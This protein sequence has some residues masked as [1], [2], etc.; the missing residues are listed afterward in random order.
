MGES[1]PV[2]PAGP[3]TQAPMKPEST[4]ARLGAVAAATVV[5]ISSA[6]AADYTWQLA[7][8][9]NNWSTAGGDTNWFVGGVGPL[10]AWA[11]GNAAILDDASG[12]TITLIGTVAPTSTTVN[13]NG[14]WALSG[15]GILGGSGTLVKNGTGTLTLSNTTANTYS[16]GTTVNGGILSLGTGGTGA[17]TSTVSALGS[18][19]ATLNTGSTLRLWIRNNAA[20]TIANNLSIAG[21]TILNED[22]NHTLAGNVT[23]GSGGATLRSKWN[24]KNLTL[25]GVMSGTGAVT[26][27]RSETSGESSSK[28]ILTNSNSHSGGTTVSSAVLDL[29]NNNA[30]DKG[31]TGVVRGTL[32]VNSPG[33][34]NLSFSNALGYSGGEKVDTLNINGATVSHTANEDQGWGIT[35]NMTGGTL[36]STG[37]GR[38]TFGDNSSLNTLAS[39]TSATVAG[40]LRI[41]EGNTGNNINF[42][43]ADGTT[44]VDLAMNAVIEQG[45]AGYGITKLG[46]GLMQLNAAN[47]YSGATNVNAGTLSLGP[48]GTLASSPVTVNSGGTFRSEVTGKTLPAMTANNGSTLAMVAAP[49]ATTNVTGALTLTNGATINVAPILGGA[50]VPGTYDLITAGSIT[51]TGSLALT[52]GGTYGPSRASGTVSINGNKIQLVI[53]GTGASLIWNNASASGVATGTW[54]TNTTA[55]FNNGGGNDVFKAFDSVTFNDTVAAGQAKTINVAGTVAPALITANN[56]TGNNY[57]L[58][59]LTAGAGTI[60]G[61]PS[62]NKIGTGTLTLGGN[63]NYLGVNGDFTAGGGTLD[64]G[65]KTLPTQ[66]KLTVSGGGTLSNGTLPVSGTFD[67][68]QG[69]VSAVLTGGGTFTKTTANTVILSGNNAISGAG[70]VSAGTLQIGSAGTTGALGS[71]AVT[72]SSGATLALNRSDSGLTFAN[73]LSGSGALALNGTNNGVSN[74]QSSYVIDGINSGFSGT[75]TATNGRARINNTTDTGTATLITGTNGGFLIEAGTF[76]N[77]FTLSGNGWGEAAGLLGALR[78]QGGTITGPIT[79]AGNARI[80]TQGGSGTISGNIGESGGAR[81]LEFGTTGATTLLTLSGASNYTGTTTLTAANLTLSGSLGNTAVSVANTSTLGGK[82]SIGGSL[83]FSGAATNLG[84]N[85]GLP[86]T[87]TV[88]GNTTFGGVTTVALTPAPGLTPGGIITLINYGSATGTTANL[89]L[90]NAAQYRQ[91]L[92]TVGAT[93]L[94]LNVGTKALTWTGTGGLTWDIATTTNWTDTVPA[95]SAYFQGDTVTFSDTAGAGNASVTVAAAL[96][97]A[98]VTVNNTGAVPYTFGGAG[99]VGGA[100][101]LVKTGNGSATLLMNMPYTGGTTVNGGSLIVDGNQEGNRQANGG[102]VTVNSGGTFEIR[103]VNA[104]PSAGNSINVT[105]NSGTLRVVTGTSAAFPAATQSHAHLGNLTLNAGT[106]DFTY[107][108]TGSAYNNESFQFNGTLTVGGSAASTIQSAESTANQGIALSGNRTFAVAD[109]TGNASPDLIITAEVENSDSNNGALT[110]TGT[111]TLSLTSANSYSAGTTIS[112]GTLLAD[113]GFSGSATGTGAVSV[114]VGATLGGDGGATGAITAAGTLAPGN[115]TTPL[116][117][118]RLGA[119]TLTGSYACQING[120]LFDELDI[121]GNLVLTG[122][123]LALSPTGAGATEASY[124]LASWTG[125]RTGTFTTVTGLPGGYFLIYDDVLKELRID[126]TPGDSYGAWEAANGIS[127]SGPDADPD[128]DGIKNGIEFVIGGDPSGPGSVSAALLPT[129]ALDGTYLNVVYRRTDDSAAFDPFVEYGS[130]LTGWT[131]AQA[132]VNGVLVSEDN[133]FYGAGIDRVTVRIPRALA[134]GSRLFA[135]LHV[136]IP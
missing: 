124:V 39:T 60:A 101:S 77:A 57:T 56:S 2:E 9:T 47:T 107:A 105:L 58:T 85:L 11:D 49:S 89:A 44:E 41:R 33:A 28:V 78:L 131:E 18:G 102:Q 14:T 3:E 34:L 108:T 115:L 16:A 68:Q 4:R 99:S 114:A 121:T 66:A 132:G 19:T 90:A 69:T 35:V 119:T 36:Q 76:A 100:A 116:G 30:T 82:G 40:F 103:G 12:E 70:T 118:L 91:A 37:T 38:F 5:A 62:I 93:S 109:A 110:K 135:R 96:T 1:G 73:A 83:N 31:G 67:F 72:I 79:L 134:V 20:F 63:L 48:N 112:A 128:S 46:T 130:A 65:A 81:N 7:G 126:T 8:T 94:T 17:D 74:G 22:G 24:G 80:T 136:D 15:A 55:N 122:A 120:T 25:T 53:I 42:T 23:V 117:L 43:T 98:A 92:F 64:L 75:M 6:H 10:A 52:F 95:A 29:G 125:T 27:L 45:A 88:T 113:N 104:L 133:N 87:L 21:G 51:G 59:A 129:S 13:N 50:S 106:V 32:T 54:D 111:G 86:G 61:S 123:T 26:V 84:V 127:G 71:G 97:P